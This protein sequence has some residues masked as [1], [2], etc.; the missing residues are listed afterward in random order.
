MNPDAL[1]PSCGIL[2]RH[3]VRECD[4]CDTTI[5]AD[6]VEEIAEDGHLVC[7]ECHARISG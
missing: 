5:E 1:C 6:E 4:L 2:G 7:D 3:H